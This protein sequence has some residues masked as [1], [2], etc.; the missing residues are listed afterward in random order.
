V[1]ASYALG[2]SITN[3]ALASN[4]SWPFVTIDNF[5]IAAAHARLDGETELIIMSPLVPGSIGGLWENYAQGSQG[6]LEESQ[7]LGY[8]TSA[9]SEDPI[10]SMGLNLTGKIPPITER[11]YRLGDDFEPVTNYSTPLYAPAWQIS[12]APFKPSLVNYDLLS[13]PAFQQLFNVLVATQGTGTGLSAFFDP[14][15]TNVL[16][17]GIYTDEAHMATHN[18]VQGGEEGLLFQPNEQP[19]TV[20]VTPIRSN[21][22]PNGGF[23]GLLSAVISSDKFLSGLL[24]EGVNGVYV[25]ITNTCNQAFTYI[26]NG[27][28]AV[29]VGPG[30]LH[31]TEYDYL[32]ETIEMSNE[33]ADTC[34]MCRMC[35]IVGSL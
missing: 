29:Y 18:M 8:Q 34:G 3:A 14:S 16:Y 5:E 21:F 28:I 22:G 12:P 30:D 20:I 31:Q 7:E 24:P 26:V 10:N 13:N 27:P 33:V 35:L 15:F 11:I 4:Q 6:W 9:W 25:V 23:V 1:G 2:D 32:E 17:E 19:H